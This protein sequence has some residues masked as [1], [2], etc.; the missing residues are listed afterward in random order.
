LNHRHSKDQAIDA[1]QQNNWCAL[2]KSCE[3]HTCV[4]S[5]REIRNFLNAISGTFLILQNAETDS[6]VHPA[7]KS[8]SI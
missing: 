8:V 1:V 5:A 2:C 4:Y 7:S 6:R 3:A